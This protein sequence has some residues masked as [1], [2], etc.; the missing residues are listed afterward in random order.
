MR[1]IDINCWTLKDWETPVYNAQCF[2][3]KIAAELAGDHRNVTT[4]EEAFSLKPPHCL[5]VVKS[6]RN[7]AIQAFRDEVAQEAKRR[8]GEGE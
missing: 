1:T 8:R 4:I 2:T 6:Y 3:S 5:R 7:P